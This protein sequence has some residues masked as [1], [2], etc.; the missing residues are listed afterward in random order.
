MAQTTGGMSGV[1]G[2]VDFSTDGSAWTAA[3]GHLM[4]VAVSGGELNTGFVH[5]SDGQFA[6]LKAGKTNPLVV[7]VNIVYNETGDEAPDFAQDAYEAASAF[8]VRWSPGGGDSGDVGYTSG[9]GYVTAQPYPGF[10]VAPGDP[11]TISVECTVPSI[12][13]AA[14]GTAGW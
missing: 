8:Y 12:T 5:T 9:A 3:N 14:I 7:T 2:H 6:I 10:D 13:R 4:S 1:V 11:L